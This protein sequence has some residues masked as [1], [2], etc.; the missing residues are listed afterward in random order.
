MI[1]IEEKYLEQIKNIIKE[2]VGR[3]K[4]IKFFIFGSSLT[5]N[6]FGDID[7]GILG[8]IK[9]KQLRLL[10]EAFKDSTLPYVVEVIDFSKVS[11]EF[12][13]NVFKQEI[14]WLEL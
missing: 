10:V 14:L 11:D 6:H 13:E 3:D 9:D 4:E 8:K 7:I 5:Q 12:K 2:T 1:M